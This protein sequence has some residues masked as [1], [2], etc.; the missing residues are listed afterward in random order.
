L[1][2]SLYSQQVQEGVTVDFETQAITFLDP[3]TNQT[4]VTFTFEEAEQA[5]MAAYG[6]AGTRERQILLFTQ[7]G[8]EWSVQE[9]GRIVG[10]DR[11]IGKLLVTESGVITATFGIPNVRTGPTP[12]PD[13][14][15]W[16][17]PLDGG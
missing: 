17:A 4:L 9:M 5:E 13:I 11:A 16:L 1:Q 3:E 12:T 10:E 2:L 14:D 6:S 8:L 15:M 7:N